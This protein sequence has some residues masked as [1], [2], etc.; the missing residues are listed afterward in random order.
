[1]LLFPALVA[2]IGWVAGRSR[3]RW[4][5]AGPLVLARRVAVVDVGV[6]SVV[7]KEEHDDDG[8][9]I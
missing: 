1:M 3:C 4:K 6:V 7:D 9:D 2:G 8:D 5:I